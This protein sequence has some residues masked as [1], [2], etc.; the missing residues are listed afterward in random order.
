MTGPLLYVGQQGQGGGVHRGTWGWVVWV[1]ESVGGQV[2]GSHG[3]TRSAKASESWRRQLTVKDTCALLTCMTAPMKS[4][5]LGCLSLAMMS[6]S[7]L[8]SCS[9]GGG[10]GVGGR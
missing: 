5:M 8:N 2:S 6:T 7:S 4:T 1:D 9:S 3:T 10:W